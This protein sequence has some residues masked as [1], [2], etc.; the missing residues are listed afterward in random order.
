LLEGSGPTTGWIS[1][2]LPQKGGVRELLEE[3][4][5][6]TMDPSQA[7]SKARGAAPASGQLQQW[8]KFLDRKK[9]QPS[10]AIQTQQQKDQSAVYPQH[11]GDFSLME[12]PYYAWQSDAE[13]GS[14]WEDYT[15]APPAAPPKAPVSRRQATSKATDKRAP[16]QQ[17][18]IDL[19]LFQMEH[20]QTMQQQ[21]QQQQQQQPSVQPSSASKSFRVVSAFDRL[22]MQNSS[23]SRTSPSAGSGRDGNNKSTCSY[24]GLAQLAPEG[25]PQ[26]WPG[27][28]RGSSSDAG[29]EIKCYACNLP[30]GEVLYPADFKE[31]A[32][33]HGECK[34]QA[35]LQHNL[36]DDF[37]RTQKEAAI[38]QEQRAKFGLG[39]KP[40]SIPRNSEFLSN[41]GK[42][43]QMVSFVLDPESKSLSL[44]PTTDPAAAVNLC[45]LAC[46]LHLRERE[47]REAIFSLDP[48]L[49]SKEQITANA[50]LW[51]KKRFEPS[52]L[53]ETA[54]GEVLFQADYHLKELSMGVAEQPVLG[55]KSSVEIDGCCGGEEWTAREWFVVKDAAVFLSEG[56]V[57]VPQAVLGV[58]AKE[59]LIGPDGLDDAPIT[60]PDHPLVR[61]AE[62]FTKNFDLIAAR[63]SVFHNLQEVAK[64]SVLAKYL[65]ES[66]INFERSW[67]DQAQKKLLLGNS[68]SNSSESLVP[69]LR[70]E[71]RRSSIQLQN[72]KINGWE[73]GLGSHL[74]IVSGGVQMGLEHYPLQEI[75]VAP[76]RISRGERQPRP[77]GF[78][79]NRSFIQGLHAG[80]P[81]PQGVDMSLSSFNLSEL[82][83]SASGEVEEH[84]A[85]GK[86]FWTCVDSGSSDA[87]CFWNRVF[88]QAL[89]DRR[90]E[91][92][93]FLPPG[94][95]SEALLKLKA[96]LEEEKSFQKQRLD[97]FSSEAFDESCPG[98]LFPSSWVQNIN[99]EKVSGTQH[100]TAKASEGLRKVDPKEASSNLNLDRVLSS[101]VLPTFDKTTEEGH[102]FRVYRWGKYIVRTVEEPTSA[103]RIVAVFEKKD[104]PSPSVGQPLL[105]SSLI[106]NITEYVELGDTTASGSDYYQQFLVVDTACGGTV[107][108][109]LQS[110]GGNSEAASSQEPSTTGFSWLEN[111]RRL[112]QRRSCAKVLR[113]TSMEGIQESGAAL[114]VKH[115]KELLDKEIATCSAGISAKRAWKRFVGDVFAR[116]ASTKE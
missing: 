92:E 72:G 49:E 89:S 22:L 15:W 64:A 43:P 95:S 16:L 67:F 71:R 33:V 36:T 46:A 39:W 105:T 94:N 62:Q 63:R 51:Q 103:H 26:Q 59:Q 76:T 77:P 13:A 54:L 3:V 2:R 102:R 53:A 107:E 70:A 5:S 11:Q 99:L 61:Y 88:D 75:V 24:E 100:P 86:A 58:E 111:S 74:R 4:P 41:L 109:E 20:Q 52:W 23:A 90:A 101:R 31:G 8:Q 10:Q 69:L 104:V 108:V 91:E 45:Y 32:F 60:R 1:T 50:E 80:L 85:C 81:D 48:V 12:A 73:E 6:K 27:L 79:V 21:Q 14:Y 68:S 19:A 96:L 28:I 65:C 83:Q 38:I 40:Q 42:N 98:S 44:V 66:G 115:V 34:A 56:N 35:C 82:T 18:L 55:M 29:L 84:L 17:H 37:K 106:A 97:H 112:P 116:A 78:E 47:G 110:R 93:L 87:A 30:L 25:G 57:V 113:A 7:S 9:Q 114:T